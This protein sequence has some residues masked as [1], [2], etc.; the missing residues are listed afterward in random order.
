MPGYEIDDVLLVVHPTAYVHQT[1]VHIGDVHIAASCYVA[2]LVSLCADF[3][4]IVVLDG[5]NLQDG[6]VVHTLPGARRSSS[7]T[8]TSATARS[9]PAAGWGRAA[10]SA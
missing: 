2:P 1:T 8:A 9:C 7:R 10:W 3:G 6:F 5:S 4:R